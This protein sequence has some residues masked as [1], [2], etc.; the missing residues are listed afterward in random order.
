MTLSL[1][2]LALAMLMASVPALTHAAV[3][4]APAS[5]SAAVSAAQEQRVL[6][7][8]PVTYSLATAL[9]QGTHVQV[10]RAAPANLPASRQSAYFTGRG[11]AA[12]NKAAQGADAAI[13]MRSIWPEDPLYP[14]ARRSH[15]RI[16]EIDAARPVDGA[17]PGIAISQEAA[18]GNY[19]WL[20]PLNMGR[21]ADVLAADLMR[22]APSDASAIQTNL[23]ALKQ[24]LL[25]VT[26]QSQQRLAKVDNLSVAS[27]SERLGYLISGLNLDQVD[28]TAPVDD[29]WSVDALGQLSETLRE[30]D[31]ALVLHHRQPPPGVVEAI[32][33]GGARL[34]VVDSDPAD[35]LAGLQA[36]VDQV[37]DAFDVH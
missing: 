11:A 3:K 16:V 22:L 4:T 30:Q 1:K 2:P 37:I 7:S 20:S 10:Q 5:P 8:L 9:L 29:D 27:L 32:E 13:G 21:M 23:A 14:L 28:V 15:L 34:V 33:R 35:S 17:L 26:A 25:S 12:L 18:F 6:T 36:S 24:R 19:P 31:V